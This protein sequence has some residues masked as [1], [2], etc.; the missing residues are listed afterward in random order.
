VPLGATF[1]QTGAVKWLVGGLLILG[2]AGCWNRTRSMACLTGPPP[3]VGRPVPDEMFALMRR[4]IDRAEDLRRSPLVRAEIL[5]TIPSLFPDV[6]DLVVAPDCAPELRTRL[7]AE[8]ARRPLPFS[9][10]ALAQ[11][12]TLWSLGD[13]TDVMDRK[14]LSLMTLAQVSD[15]E[16]DR[17]RMTSGESGNA[18]RPA[19]V[20]FWALAGLIGSNLFANVAEVRAF[21]V[22]RLQHATDDR[23]Q[24]L[25]SWLATQMFD[26]VRRSHR[27]GPVDGEAPRLL[28]AWIDDT[29]RRLA[30][31]GDRVAFEIVHT[32]LS[33]IGGYGVVF[34]LTAPARAVVQR[35]LDAR[36]QLP[37]AAAA[38]HGALDLAM[39]ARAALYELDVPHNFLYSLEA[40][41]IESTRF[42]P[43]AE[44]V[45]R[46]PTTVRFADADRATRVRELDDELGRLRFASARC[47]VLRQLVAWAPPGDAERRYAGLLAPVLIGARFALSSEV[48]CRLQLALSYA[49]IDD[50]RRAALALR[51]LR[52][53][54]SDIG[55]YD[56]RGDEHHPALVITTE[57][58][59]LWGTA[60]AAVA[61]HPAWLAANAE[62][63]DWLVERAV[64]NPP[65][66]ASMFEL[67]LGGA[68][69]LL[70]VALLTWDAEHDREQGRRLLRAW[71]DAVRTAP[72]G[73]TTDALITLI[74]RFA[75]RFDLD[76]EARAV[77]DAILAARELPSDP[78]HPDFL[79]RTVTLAAYRLD[80]R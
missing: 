8:L 69:P 33:L 64:A 18:P 76:A 50:A 25:L 58:E 26:N 29:A 22:D 35:V 44:W 19:L 63:R 53:P 54:L 68:L 46:S 56:D 70:H 38:D 20:R 27:T 80:L 31:P 60:L 17:Y 43:W 4:E 78:S 2:L 57:K 52:T 51:V 61:A 45:H 42:Q 74:G 16:I 28:R 79:L 7:H 6:S 67:D 40:P 14:G 37:V 39:A 21:L 23:E 32:R 59:Q 41:A 73:R 48:L 77:F 34:G 3:R 12:R 36:G 72:A 71:L 15:A 5:E 55:D 75:G 13:T 66:G 49:A 1:R 62:L 47:H 10:L 30:R 65:A 9:R 11:L 24:L